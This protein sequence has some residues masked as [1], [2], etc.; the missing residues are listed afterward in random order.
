MRILYFSFVELDIPNACRTH[1]IG[2]IKGFSRHGYRVDALIPKP[3]KWV[4]SVPNVRFIFLRP[5]QFSNIGSFWIR[6][7]SAFVMIWLCLKNKYDF[8]YIRE[9]EI[10]PGPRWCA[11]LFKLPLYIEVNDLLVPTYS[12]R[13][14]SKW[15]VKMVSKNQKKDFHLAAGLIVPSVPMSSWLIRHYNLFHGK[16]HFVP[17]GV[18]IPYKEPL[19]KMDARKRLRMPLDCFCI[20]FV[21]NIY[22]RYDFETLLKAID[23][24]RSKNRKIFLLIIGDGP[25][26][27][28]LE[29]EVTRHGMGSY[30]IFTGF[31]NPELLGNYVPAIDAGV[32]ILNS[33]VARRYGPLNTKSSTYGIFKTAVIVSCISSAGYPKELVDPLFF[34]EPESPE[35]LADVIKRL[36]DD[37]KERE[38]RANMFHSIVKSKMTWEA[39]ADLILRIV[40]IKLK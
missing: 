35:A 7:I 13:G 28:A 1:T 11:R 19:K 30:S 4:A 17:N 34:A 36:H 22:D 26:K 37:P 16:V 18:E 6:L 33:E 5:W 25:L 8:I 23:I 32:I 3:I 40:K 9:L 12:S 27:E 24:C 10:N 14:A 21:G 31:V 38:R 2:I 39:C 29:K 15:L 20:G